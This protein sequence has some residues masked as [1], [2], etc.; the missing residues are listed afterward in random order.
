V[1]CVM[2]CVITAQATAALRTGAREKPACGA[3]RKAKG[4]VAQG[5][6]D[7]ARDASTVRGNQISETPEVCR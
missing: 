6:R 3:R 4:E 7:S 1:L 5:G 2:C